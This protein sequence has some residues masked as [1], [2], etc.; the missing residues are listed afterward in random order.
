MDGLNAVMLR[1]T[2]V[3]DVLCERASTSSAVTAMYNRRG[4]IAKVSSS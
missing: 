3:A 2:K 1:A 4:R